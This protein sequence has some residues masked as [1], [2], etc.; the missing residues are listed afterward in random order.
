MY[1]NF[2]KATEATGDFQRLQ[3]EASSND[4]VSWQLSLHRGYRNIMELF[5]VDRASIGQFR[6][7]LEALIAR[8]VDLEETASRHKVITEDYTEQVFQDINRRQLRQAAPKFIGEID[9]LSAIPR[10]PSPGRKV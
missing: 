3:R 4:D 2:L 7:Q 1:Q 5:K 10:T 6:N 8:S 9:P